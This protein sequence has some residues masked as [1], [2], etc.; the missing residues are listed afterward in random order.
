MN[1]VR[2]RPTEF[3]VDPTS[4]FSADLLK[5]QAPAEDLTELVRGSPEGLVIA[6]HAPWGTGKS[7]FLEMWKHHLT[8]KGV[9]TLL[10]NAWRTDFCGDPLVALMGELELGLSS[11][12]SSADPFVSPALASALQRARTTGA[13]LLKRALPVGVKLATAGLLN[14]DELIEDEVSELAKSV[15]EDRI[16]AYKKANESIEA[17]LY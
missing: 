10:F 2:I 9:N 8:L 14:V 5:R 7:T 17:W 3:R 1:E 4:P 12:K 13:S 11:L 6:L 16:E 15:T